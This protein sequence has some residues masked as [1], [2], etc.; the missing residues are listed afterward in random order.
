MID[1]SQMKMEEIETHGQEKSTEMLFSCQANDNFSAH[2]NRIIKALFERPYCCQKEGFD[3]ISSESKENPEELKEKISNI[4][5][6][7]GKKIYNMFDN[8]LRR[9]G[10][11]VRRKTLAEAEK[12][13]QQA[14]IEAQKEAE[15]KAQQAR[16]EAEKRAQ[17][18]EKKLIENLRKAGVSEEQILKAL[19]KKKN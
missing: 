17:Q 3:Y 11:V 16:I 14:R 19:G 4:A 6:I 18:A 13:A 10:D 15:K 2:L 5:G 1:L 7:Q 8:A 12:K 9:H